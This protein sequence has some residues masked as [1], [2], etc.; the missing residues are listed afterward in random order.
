L[1]NQATHEEE[2][3]TDEDAVILESEFGPFYEECQIPR[4]LFWSSNS[5]ER[6]EYKKQSYLLVF[7]PD[8]NAF[9]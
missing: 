3:K 7:M 4:P 8:A 1:C 6:V 9:S 5:R 2:K